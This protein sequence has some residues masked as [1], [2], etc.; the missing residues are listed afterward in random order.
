MTRRSSSSDLY[1]LPRPAFA[2][3]TAAEH[4]AIASATYAHLDTPV[5]VEY[6]R[7]ALRVATRHTTE[8]TTR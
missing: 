6:R 8:R 2:R 3:L 4:A 1:P 5:V 7:R